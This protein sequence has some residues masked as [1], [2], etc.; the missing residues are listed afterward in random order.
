MAKAEDTSPIV[1]FLRFW[2]GTG[3]LAA[4]A[5]YFFAIPELFWLGTGLFYLV[6]LTSFIQIRYEFRWG[7]ETVQRRVAWLAVLLVALIFSYEVAFYPA[8]L[9]IT[10]NSFEGLYPSGTD[11]Y[12]IT[13][14]EDM[15]DLRLDLYNS[16]DRNFEKVVMTVEVPKLFIH[17]QHQVTKF[18]GVDLQPKTHELH[19]KHDNGNGKP[20]KEENKSVENYTT[21]S[22]SIEKIPKHSTVGLIFAIT[23]RSSIAKKAMG[24]EKN[25]TVYVVPKAPPYR[26]NVRARPDTVF[27]QGSYLV[28]NRPHEVNEFVKVHQE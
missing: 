6:L 26:Y 4:L 13:W 5:L 28:L 25:D 8:N 17:G 7:K 11:V 9:Q 14:D 12:G 18:P 23:D 21:V 2:N 19:I 16:T 15:S 20:S 22:V 24:E 10:A 3:L 27:I 1:L